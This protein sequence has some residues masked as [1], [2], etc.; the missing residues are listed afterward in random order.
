MLCHPAHSPRASPPLEWER[1]RGGEKNQSGEHGPGDLARNQVFGMGTQPVLKKRHFR[2]WRKQYV[3]GPYSGKVWESKPGKIRTGCFVSCICL[4]GQMVHVWQAWN[5]GQEIDNHRKGRKE[6]KSLVRGAISLSPAFLGYRDRELR[7]PFIQSVIH[8]VV[9]PTNQSTGNVLSIRGEEQRKAT[10]T[11]PCS[12]ESRRR[13][14][15][16]K[17]LTMWHGQLGDK[18]VWR[19][20]GCRLG[21]RQPHTLGASFRTQDAASMGGSRRFVD[22]VSI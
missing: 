1:W 2:E 19:G 11:G 3:T 21:W 16:M 22:T 8:L 12:E 18:D 5:K 7:S 17:I 15:H 13:S 14:G 9:H 6:W 20:S 10:N 4:A